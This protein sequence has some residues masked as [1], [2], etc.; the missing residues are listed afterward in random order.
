MRRSTLLHEVVKICGV[1]GLALAKEM[2]SLQTRTLRKP[3]IGFKQ[4]TTLVEFLIFDE[5]STFKYLGNN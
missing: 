1:E 3:L 2:F 4:R 5:E